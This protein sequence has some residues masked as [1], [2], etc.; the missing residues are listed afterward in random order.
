VHQPEC[1]KNTPYVIDFI[2]IMLSAK[3]LNPEEIRFQYVEKGLSVPQIA[4]LFQVSKSMIRVRLHSLGIRDGMGS[5]RNH[6]PENYRCPVA[7][8]GYQV[9]AGKLISN[10][11]ELHICRTVVTL[12]D[13]DGFTHSEVARE[14]ARRGHKTR[15]GKTKWDSKTIFN[16]Y[17]RWH[18][19]I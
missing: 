8:Y 11:R 15:T 2:K 5:G 3:L 14:L 12:V 17:K 19:K 4:K 9:Q 13:R 6:N 16:I 7:P 10:K 1:G 18:G